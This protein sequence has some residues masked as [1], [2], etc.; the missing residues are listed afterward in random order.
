MTSAMPLSRIHLTLGF[1]AVFMFSTVGFA[2][3]PSPAL[4]VK[5]DDT[6][7]EMVLKKLDVDVRIHGFLA[8]TTSTMT[9]HNPHN[10][11]LEGDM[12]FPL[13]QGATV[14]GYALDIKEKLVDGVAV[15]K[16]GRGPFLRRL[17]ARA[18]TPD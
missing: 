1:I 2:Q 10:R 16:P 3:E 9:F 17:S 12:Y 18:S 7:Q 14:N 5:Q 15:E 8:E 6:Y 11:V 4:L 13:P